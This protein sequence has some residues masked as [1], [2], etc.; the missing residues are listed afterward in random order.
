MCAAR[1]SEGTAGVLT[2]VVV[3]ARSL[4]ENAGIL[5]GSFPPKSFQFNIGHYILSLDTHSV[6]RDSARKQ[7]TIYV[8]KYINIPRGQ[9]GEFFV[10]KQVVYI[11]TT[12]L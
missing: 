4:H 12:V 8:G 2:F 10:L 3:F 11:V 5:H 6:L 7:M 1:I 9:N